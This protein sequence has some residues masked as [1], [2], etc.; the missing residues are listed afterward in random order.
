MRRNNVQKLSLIA[1]L[2]IPKVLNDITFAFS[3]PIDNPL[4]GEY[5]IFRYNDYNIFYTQKGS[6]HPLLLIHGIGAGASSYSFRKNFD[7]LSKD[8]KVYAIDLL[9]F[10]QSDRPRIDYTAELFTDI[11]SDFVKYI[12]KQKTAVVAISLSAAFVI[13]AASK[14]PLYFDKM[15]LVGPTG[16]INLTKPTKVFEEALYRTLRSPYMGTSVY[17]MITSRMGIKEFLKRNLY[18]NEEM[19]TDEMIEHYYNSCH[20]KGINSK[21]ATASF[22]SGHMNADISEELQNI[23]IPMLTIWGKNAK[24]SPEQESKEFEDLNSNVKTLI[25]KDCGMSPNEEYSQKLNDDVLS[26]L[27][28]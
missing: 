3:K 18:Y 28:Q 20:F 24:L 25:Y 5:K 26:F 2:I 19:V 8:Y 10:G 22:L 15:V 9:G 23:T 1:A 17:N 7:E 6:G 13:K 27:S 11:I 16:I 12:I 14:N 21:Y 4:L